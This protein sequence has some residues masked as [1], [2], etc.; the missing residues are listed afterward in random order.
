V[1]T[2]PHGVSTFGWP[3]VLGC[4]PYRSVKELVLETDELRDG[5]AL[6]SSA[7]ISVEWS[8]IVGDEVADSMEGRW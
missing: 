2:V 5:V 8:D 3:G 6:S 1:F 4:L 7:I